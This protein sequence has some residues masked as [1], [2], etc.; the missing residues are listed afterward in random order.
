MSFADGRLTDD[1]LRA[2]ARRQA[3]TTAS[4]AAAR[5][6][7]DKPAWHTSQPSSAAIAAARLRLSSEGPLTAGGPRS[8]AA[9]ASE[10]TVN[11]PVAALDFELS[12]PML[13]M[14]LATFKRQCRI[15]KSVK[16]WR[17]EALQKGWLVVHVNDASD[18]PAPGRVVIFISHT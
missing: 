7:D 12:A 3:A 5:H 10:P 16:R 1:Q 15:F 6:L 13:V 8:S 2:W 17:D 9:A 11:D 4:F 14:P 18:R